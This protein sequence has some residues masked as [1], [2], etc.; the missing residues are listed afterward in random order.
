MLTLF[1]KIIIYTLPLKNITLNHDRINISVSFPDQGG[2]MTLP[3]EYQFLIPWWQS[4]YILLP[5]CFPH[6]N[7]AKKP[8]EGHNHTVQNCTLS[9]GAARRLCMFS[10]NR[11]TACWY[12]T[13]KQGN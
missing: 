11:L 6:Y 2:D 3:L 13:I 5:A 4:G 12:L 1:L 10:L 7:F 8:L 9:R